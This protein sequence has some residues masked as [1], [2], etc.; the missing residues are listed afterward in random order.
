MRGRH[1]LQIEGGHRDRR[2]VERRLRVEGDQD[3]EEDRIDAEVVQERQEDRNEDDDDLRP[4]QR[5]AQQEDD[6]LGQ[7]QE[8]RARQIEAEEEL[9]ND[10]LTA[11]RARWR[12]AVTAA[13]ITVQ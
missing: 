7:D 13:R 6:E 2:R 1:S 12:E 8:L 10:R 3:A 4:L 5:P 9:L 11:E